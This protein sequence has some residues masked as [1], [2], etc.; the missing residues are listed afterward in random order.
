VA[1]RA[2]EEGVVLGLGRE[3][4]QFRTEGQQHRDGVQVEERD[5]AREEGE[6]R[7]Q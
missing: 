2:A 4:V 6:G 7:Q 5:A 1:S 3:A